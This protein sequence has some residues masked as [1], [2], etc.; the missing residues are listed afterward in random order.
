MVTERQSSSG[1][2]PSCLASLS[3]T[4]FLLSTV[5]SLVWGEASPPPPLSGGISSL[6]KLEAN[7]HDCYLI[8]AQAQK[9]TLA[10]PRARVPRAQQDV[11]T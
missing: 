7:D 6:R 3:H 9:K 2:S 10:A 8:L 1:R 5:S 11:R 4:L